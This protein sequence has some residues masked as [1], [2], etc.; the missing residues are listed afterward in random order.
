MQLG[1]G[2]IFSLLDNKARVVTWVP[3]ACAVCKHQTQPQSS[4]ALMHCLQRRLAHACNSLARGR[5]ELCVDGDQLLHE[6]S[7]H[8]ALFTQ[9]DGTLRL[10][11]LHHLHRW[12]AARPRLA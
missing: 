12:Q 1:S 11:Q 7:S 3:M 2:V 10:G 5:L 8:L 6:G 9:Q 4:Q